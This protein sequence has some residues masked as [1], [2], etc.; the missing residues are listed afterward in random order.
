MIERTAEEQSFMKHGGYGLVAQ[1]TYGE[2]Y[3][4]STLE[5]QFGV[6]LVREALH[7][8][9]AEVRPNSKDKDDIY[10]YLTALGHNLRNK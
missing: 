6:E 10:L 7:L 9:L 4:K 3:R 5:R 2:P 8:G 1:F